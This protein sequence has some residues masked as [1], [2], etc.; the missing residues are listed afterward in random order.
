[1]MMQREFSFLLKKNR[2]NEDIS[3]FLRLKGFLI[4]MSYIQYSIPLNNERTTRPQHCF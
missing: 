2:D 4:G 3:V 1:M